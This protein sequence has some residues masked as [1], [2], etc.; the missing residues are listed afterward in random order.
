LSNWVSNYFQVVR[1]IASPTFKNGL[2]NFPFTTRLQ[3]LVGQVDNWSNLGRPYALTC[4]H[5]TQVANDT[6]TCPNISN[7]SITS[8]NS[9]EPSLLKRKEGI[10]ETILFTKYHCQTSSLAY[11][12]QGSYCCTYYIYTN[13][14]TWIS[15]CFRDHAFLAFVFCAGE[16]KV[17]LSIHAHPFWDLL[18]MTLSLMWQVFIAF[19][20]SL[21]F[22]SFSY[23]LLCHV[24]KHVT[25]LNI[26]M[27]IITL[28]VSHRMI[29]KLI[30]WCS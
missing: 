19:C 13:E 14:C 9:Q 28:C 15:E 25:D 23:F 2:F 1:F 20:F 16:K 17:V 11:R 29:C 26:Q 7:S 8:K 27:F 21:F 5:G 6:P 3:D 18:T 4:L 24:V 10:L 30:I 22:L 12:R